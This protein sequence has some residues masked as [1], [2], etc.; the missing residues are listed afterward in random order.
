MNTIEITKQEA[1]SQLSNAMHRI[2]ELK[3]RDNGS[4][5]ELTLSLGYGFMMKI[6]LLVVCDISLDDRLVWS[7]MLENFMTMTWGEVYI[8]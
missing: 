6:D 2:E 8:Y 1:I 5:I 7:F 4:V 3:S